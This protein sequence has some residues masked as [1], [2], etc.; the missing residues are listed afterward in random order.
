MAF[1]SCGYIDDPAVEKGIH[2]LL[3]TQREDGTWDEN[4]FTGTGF[5][6]VFYLEYTYYRQY[7]PLLAL[8][9]FR[10]LLRHPKARRKNPVSAPLAEIV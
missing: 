4:E 7:F 8:G 9:M 2:Y 3:S 1:L 5:P 10:R 6:K